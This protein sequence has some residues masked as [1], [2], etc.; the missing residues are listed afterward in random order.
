MADL[1]EAERQAKIAQLRNDIEKIDAALLDLATGKLAG[2]LTI[3]S[4]EMQRRYSYQELT[5]ET[6]EVVKVMLKKKLQELDVPV[7]RFVPA[8]SPIVWVK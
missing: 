2:S 8:F 4:G 7:M 5:I 1:T 3:G 6:A